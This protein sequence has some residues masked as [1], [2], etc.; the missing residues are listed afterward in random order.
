MNKLV[1]LLGLVWWSACQRPDDATLRQGLPYYHTPDFTPV[2]LRG[3]QALD[4][5]HRL[6]AFRLQ[7]QLG[8]VV[9][10]SSLIG[11]IHVA[12]FFFTACPSLCPRLMGNLRAVA[13]AFAKDPSVKLVSY[14]VIPERDS[15]STLRQYAQAHRLNDRKWWLLTG[16]RKMIYETARKSY[17]ADENLGIQKG[18]NDF[19]HTENV[20][21]VD[22]HLRIRGIY[23]GSLPLEI[24]QLIADIKTLQAERTPQSSP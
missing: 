24:E 9:S 19:L 11:K 12:N 16:D 7:N 13:I 17:F 14:S 3:E 23:N 4:T 22:E 21:L 5:L 20:L 1:V 15:V 2:W 8:E 6:K 18:E 10:D